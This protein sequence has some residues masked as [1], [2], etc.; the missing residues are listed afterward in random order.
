MGA[1]SIPGGFGPN[2]EVAITQYF[3]MLVVWEAT[4]ISLTN[5][6]RAWFWRCEIV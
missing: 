6:A 2:I 5:K 1:S 4:P 3:R